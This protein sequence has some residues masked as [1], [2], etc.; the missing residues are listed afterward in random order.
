MSGPV[1]DSCGT[2][3]VTDDGLRFDL[4][5]W[6]GANHMVCKGGCHDAS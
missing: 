2:S 4:M 6:G 1:C 5:Y 3:L